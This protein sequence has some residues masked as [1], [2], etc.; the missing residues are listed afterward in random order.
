[1]SRTYGSEDNECSKQIH[2]V[3]KVLAVESLPKRP[4]LVGP[5]KEEVEKGN[6]GAFKLG[7]S[8]SID[9]GWGESLPDNRFAN[10][11]SDEQRYSRSATYKYRSSE[12]HFEVLTQARIP[13]VAAHRV[14]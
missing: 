10:I 13:F 7:S 6:D 5:C 8:A 9:G 11:G 14:E 4:L 12:A 3:R 1:M 2:D